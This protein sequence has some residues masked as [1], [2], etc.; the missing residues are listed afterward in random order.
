MGC[1]ECDGCMRCQDRLD[2]Y[3]EPDYDDFDEL[4][5][6]IARDEAYEKSLEK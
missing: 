1:W 4:A 5:S 6:D 2:E 3:T